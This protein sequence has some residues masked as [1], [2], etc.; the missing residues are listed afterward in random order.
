MIVDTGVWI[1]YFA[2]RASWQT[3]RLDAQIA[4]ARLVALTDVVYTELLQGIQEDD[5]LRFT[6]R[7]LLK[8]HILRL[9]GLDDFRLAA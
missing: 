5:H 2:G 9:G 7:K 6:E 8:F 1:D 3:D 4:D